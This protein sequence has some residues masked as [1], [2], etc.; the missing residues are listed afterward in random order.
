MEEEMEEE[1]KGGRKVRRRRKEKGKEIRDKLH[2]SFSNFIS[3][4]IIFHPYIG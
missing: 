1:K 3:C 2:V 4:G